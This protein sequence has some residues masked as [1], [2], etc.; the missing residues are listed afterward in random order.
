MIPDPIVI[1]VA[2]RYGRC[3]SLTCYN[4]LYGHITDKKPMYVFDGKRMC[5]ECTRKHQRTLQEA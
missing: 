2:D 1:P 5:K 3:E 4:R